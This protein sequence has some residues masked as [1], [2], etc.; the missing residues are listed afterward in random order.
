M[1]AH[2]ERRAGR[3]QRWPLLVVA[4]LTAVCTLFVGGGGAGP[5]YTLIYLLATLPGQP[6]GFALFGARHPAGWIAGML[7][8]YALSAFSLWV[9]IALGVPSALA[10]ITA[11]A[12]VNVMTWTAIPWRR[13]ALIELPSWEDRASLG[14]AIVLTL[15]LALITPPFARV[16][17][18]DAIGHHSYRAY[19]TADFV[20]HTAL[21]AELS[22]FSMPPRNPYLASQPLHYYWTYFLLPATVSAR[23]PSRLNDVQLDL[24]V[25]ALLTGVLLMSAVFM[26]AWA[27]VG[28]AWSVTIAVCL[29]L[30]AASAE[31]TYELYRF[32]SRGQALIGLRDVNIDAITAWHFQGLRLDGLPRCL[33]YVPQHSMAYALGLVALS[34]AAAIGSAGSTLT[35]ALCGLALAGSTMMNPF[36]GGLFAAA[37]GIAVT[38]DAL[39][40]PRALSRVAVHALAAIPVAG[41]VLWCVGAQMVEGA[42]DTLAFGFW[43]PA[44][45]SPLLV[46]L[47]S[48]GPVLVPAAAGVVTRR[49]GRLRTVVPAVVLIVVSLLVMYLVR[50]RVDVAWVPF[51]A[52]QMLLVAIP[53]LVA[54]AVATLAD[55]RR[56]LAAVAIA[57]L[58][59]IGTPTTIIDAFNA[60]DIEDH[61]IGPGFHWTL[62]LDANEERAL[63]W[64][65]TATPKTALVQMEPS[66]RDRELSAGHWGE[67]WSLIPTFAERRMAAGLPISLMRVPEYAEKSALVKAIYETSDPHHAWTIAHRLRIAYLY[68]DALD[69]AAYA[70]VAK[71]ETSPEYFTTAFSSGDVRV[72]AVK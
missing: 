34:G 59:V 66:V 42:G 63:N 15:T 54:R 46:L 5:L 47:L 62:V 60:Q 36:V 39:R 25:N 61:D 72:F 41:A 4:A 58:F 45:Y 30:L 7:L 56:A 38:I 20:W 1:D 50:L 44:A 35:I 31:G 48:L 51:R 68:V 70:G 17:E 57:I 65:R 16:G 10:L 6:I 64:I 2:P 29:T 3:Y 55:S 11:W 40:T 21:T 12:V 53:A 18:T 14:L 24:K 22:K 49:D 43:G 69:R 19:F 33:W 26:A 71:F 9:P 37:W 8:G 52:G 13:P 23:G 32:W 67:R 28:R 27:A